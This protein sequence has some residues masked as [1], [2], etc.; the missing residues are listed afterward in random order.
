[1]TILRADALTISEILEKSYLIPRFQRPYSWGTEEIELFYN[2]I[3]ENTANYFIGH[4]VTYKITDDKKGVID[5]QQRLTT[6]TLALCAIRNKF[7]E[8]GEKKLSEGVQ[9]YIQKTDRHGELQNILISE[10]SSPFIK[11]SFQDIPNN[12]NDIFKSQ[13]QTEEEKSLK[14]AYDQINIKI[15]EELNRNKSK[16][17]KK[18][19]LENLRDKLLDVTLV[20]VELKDKDSAYI[21]FQ[22]LNSTGK[23]LDLIDLIKSQLLNFLRTDTAS[24]DSYKDRWDKMIHSLD[25]DKVL[26]DTFF[27]HFWVSRNG[28]VTKAKIFKQFRKCVSKKKDAENMLKNIID[29]S[30]IYSFIENP[31]SDSIFKPINITKSLKAL[32]IFKVSLAHPFILSLLR[33]YK[34]KVTAKNIRECLE[35]IEYFHFLYTAIISGRASGISNKYAAF[36]RRLSETEDINKQNKMVK[37]L[38]FDDKFPTFEEFHEKIQEKIYYDKNTK[39]K[40]LIRY[41]LTQLDKHLNLNEGRTVDYDKMT[42]EHIVSQTSSPAGKHIGMIGNLILVDEATQKKL[43]TKPLEQKITILHSSGFNKKDFIL[44]SDLKGEEWIKDRTKKL[45]ILLYE[46]FTGKKANSN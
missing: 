5:G 39:D 41:I 42:I 26:P 14:S 10:S 24:S 29:D 45:S 44:Y 19:F 37:E 21:I 16:F 4:M 40:N 20:Y 28:L 46:I 8:I 15:V 25:Q 13:A 38:K 33:R 1:M 12:I 6:I 36:A 2:D 43:Q 27:Q 17:S 23:D 30:I 9:K 22:T 18:K 7:I 3:K 31:E 32:R 35:R 11:E 34:N